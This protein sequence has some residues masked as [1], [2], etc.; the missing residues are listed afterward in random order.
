MNLIEGNVSAKIT[1]DYTMGS[2]SHNTL[3]RNWV[4]GWRSNPPI[5][6]GVWAIDIQNFNRY[7]NIVGNVI[8]LPSWT[9]GTVLADNN[10]T[11]EEP[12]VYRFGCTGQPGGYLDPWLINSNH[13]LIM[14]ISQMG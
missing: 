8:G 13:T 14:T 6:W 2:S 9:T 5:G 11:P 4:R 3:F 10:C 1:H 7:F 12:A